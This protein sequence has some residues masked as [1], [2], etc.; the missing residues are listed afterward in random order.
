MNG[1]QTG[2]LLLYLSLLFASTYFLAGFLERI[3]IPG[4]LAA[5]LVA[6]AV[7]YTPLGAVILS[8]EFNAP[9]AFLAELG[10]LF[11][12][13]YIG[14]QIKF[15]EMFKFSG[16]IVRLTVL[17]TVVPFFL[18]TAVMLALGY[19]WL[20]AFIIGLTCMP[21]AEAVIVPILDEFK[22]IHTRVGQF[23]IGAGVL[24]DVIEVF[25]VSFV[26]VWIGQ[27]SA[28]DGPGILRLAGGSAAFILLAR[29]LFSKGLDLLSAWM[30]KR[31]QNLMLLSILVMFGLGGL[32][33]YVGL[34]MVVGA[35]VA[36]VIMRP[37]FDKMKKIGVEV[38]HTIQSGSYGF[39]GLV[40]FFW[41]GLNADLKGIIEDP[42]L[43]IVLF[44]AA[45]F[46]K[47]IGAF[48]MVPMGRLTVREG[49]VVGIGINARLTTEIIVVQ[50]LYNAKL[51]DVHLFTA[52]L[53]AASI[54]TITVP[55]LFSL[56]MR[57]WGDQLKLHPILPPTDSAAK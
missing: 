16:D 30:P 13:F 47:L 39:L 43:A 4:I 29:F 51:I 44:L 56:L 46:G 42:A 1:P 54:S 38:S 3:H 24:D 35:I 23:I 25:L 49:W 20:I 45:F 5:L 6:M 27:M 14:L 17:N 12:L 32:S 36:G 28:Q 7:H 15:Q 48:L 9:F 55:L 2:E 34:G 53:S 21:T 26:S 22:L 50:L 52:L 19:G 8:P 41:V 18:G 11:L 33:E 57:R 37:Q 10:V 40:F 31:P